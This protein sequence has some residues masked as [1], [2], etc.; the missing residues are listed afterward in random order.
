MKSRFQKLTVYT[1]A[2]LMLCAMVPAFFVSAE[3]AS[4]A[5]TIHAESVEVNVLSSIQLTA[6]VTGVTGVPSFKWSSSDSSKATVNRSGKV[7][8]IAVG[9]A[10]ISVTASV[11]GL[12]LTDEITIYV[13][14][15]GNAIRDYLKNRQV[16][17]YQYS[18]QD[19]Y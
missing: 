4:P 12:T 16:F 7:T 14:K 10:T 17:S 6:E 18:Y 3:D 1:L 5:V 15:R 2:L 8:G 9:R 13:V 19:D 11:D